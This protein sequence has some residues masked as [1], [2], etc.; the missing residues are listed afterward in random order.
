MA[1]VES[2]GRKEGKSKKESKEP[3]RRE[4]GLSGEKIQGKSRGKGFMEWEE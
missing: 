1:K 2:K 3:K 4:R